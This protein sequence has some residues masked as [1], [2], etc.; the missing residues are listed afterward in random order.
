[1]E[2][3]ARD[4][5]ISSQN[6]ALQRQTEEMEHQLEELQEQS[7]EMQQQSEEL[8]VLQNL[9]AARERVLQSL[10]HISTGI[11]TRGDAQDMFRRI[12]ESTLQ[13]FEDS[14]FGAV[15]LEC[16]DG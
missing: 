4:E 5:E 16:V 1:E 3:A 10:F 13:A 14:A 6:E 15:L 9:A 2:L 12:C 7:E 8:Q 11:G